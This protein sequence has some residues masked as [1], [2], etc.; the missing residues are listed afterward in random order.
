MQYWVFPG[1]WA[2]GFVNELAVATVLI[3]GGAIGR[4]I[5]TLGR[6]G[7][8]AAQRQ[9][10]PWVA[11]VVGFLPIVGNAAYPAQLL[12][13]SAADTRGLARFILYDSL[14]RMGRAVPIWG[15]ADSLL[16]HRFNRLGDVFTRWLGGRDE[17]CEVRSAA[18]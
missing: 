4:T 7:Q 15:G 8:A 2:V 14:A 5:Y 18:T 9:R 17:E 11:L 1:L 16:E 6:M 10:L 3:M 13:C 12:Y